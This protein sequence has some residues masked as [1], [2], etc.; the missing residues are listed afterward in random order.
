MIMEYWASWGGGVAINKPLILIDELIDFLGIFQ[1]IE[2]DSQGEL[3][4]ANTQH[5][6]SVIDAL[7][8]IVLRVCVKMFAFKLARIFRVMN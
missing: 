2:I 1:C 6:S 4:S 8:V 3:V 7:K 5:C